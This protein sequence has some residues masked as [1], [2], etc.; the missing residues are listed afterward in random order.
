MTAA[1]RP[2]RYTEEV[3]RVAKSSLGVS[4]GKMLY[5]PHGRVGGQAAEPPPG[6]C[7]GQARGKA[8]SSLRVRDGVRVLFRVMVWVMFWV[9]VRNMVMA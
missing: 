8:V 9:K 3:E 4:L 2:A 7:L 6:T 1:H 5:K